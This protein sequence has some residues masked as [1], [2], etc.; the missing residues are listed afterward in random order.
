MTTVQD[1]VDALVALKPSAAQY[2]SRSHANFRHP[3][4]GAQPLEEYLAMIRDD[5]VEWLRQLPRTWS[6]KTALDNAKA[7]VTALCRC[8]AVAT[9]HRGLV[10]DVR[11]SIREALTPE[12]VQAEVRERSATGDDRTPGDDRAPGDDR[13]PGDDRA[14]GGDDS[15]P[16]MDD[17][18]RDDSPRGCD[19]APCDDDRAQCDGDH[20]RGLRRAIMGVCI[21]TDQAAT[22]A[23]LSPLID[24]VDDPRV[25]HGIAELVCADAHVSLVLRALRLSA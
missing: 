16:G 19:R 20:V 5:P 23:L 6:C 14:R 2:F 7:A 22:H 12:V 17:T 3:A 25:L 11:R 15:T 21:A 18:P 10:D 8:D 13:M 24:G 4:G 9:A 1:A